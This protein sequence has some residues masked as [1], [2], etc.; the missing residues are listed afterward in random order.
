MARGDSGS[1]RACRRG[2]HRRVRVGATGWAW[3]N[4]SGGV[5]LDIRREVRRIANGIAGLFVLFKGELIGGAINLTQVINARVRL[6]PGAGA[7]KVG[8]RDRRQ[9]PDD[10]HDD[11][12][13]HEGE[14][15]ALGVRLVVCMVWFHVVF[16]Y[17]R[18]EQCGWRVI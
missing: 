16:F 13:F 3:R 7:H 8:N 15:G 9:E 10:G 1:E 12:D 4:A 2:P 17:K 6:S 14:A 11:H 5:E 18:R